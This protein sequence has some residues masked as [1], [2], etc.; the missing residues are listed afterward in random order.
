[1]ETILLVDFGST[2]T[3]ITAIDTTLSRIIGTA[4]SRTTVE[5]DI[6]QG[7][8]AA[9]RNLEKETGHLDIVQLKACSSAAGGLRMLVSGLIERLTAEAA[10]QAALGA[11][12]KVLK[13]F[14][15]K[16]TKSDA[17][18]IVAANPDLFLLTGGTDGGDEECILSNAKTIASTDL[19]CPIL[20][21]GNRNAADECQLILANSG[22]TS[23]ICPN[24]MPKLGKLD[25]QPVQNEIRSLF[26]HRIIQ[27]K[28]LSKI[29]ELLTGIMMPTP[30]AVL[31]A[32]K[33]LSKG[34]QNEK[35]IGDLMAID[36]GGATCD[37]YSI[38]EGSPRAVNT[39]IKGLP[40]PFA[41]RTVEGDIGMRINARG[42]MEAAGL[43]RLAEVSHLDQ[44]EI[45]EMIDRM[46]QDISILPTTAK[47]KALDQALAA[48]A[49]EIGTIR[50]AGT[51]EETYTPAGL[52]YVQEGKDLRDVRKMLFIGGTLVRGE[53]FLHTAEFCKYSAR[54]PLSLR[55]ENFTTYIDKKYIISALGLLA[56][57]HPVEA[58]RLMKKEIVYE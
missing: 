54:F 32:L 35:G 4:Q 58:I 11:G 30:V 23:I 5:S 37:V 39:V 45:R 38:A 6:A 18:E 14:S 55:P 27:A 8:V 26:M 34:T 24:V 43:D 20:I 57:S 44:K 48:L 15:R 1:M 16:L 10:R 56:G 50:H 12:A 53:D 47:L 52:T 9:V 42:V 33:L 3:K 13:V 49:M 28:G 51:I 22:K 21:A 19:K 31:E 7:M 29:Q 46:T 2:Y 17:Q 41:K 25:I 36:L 40:E